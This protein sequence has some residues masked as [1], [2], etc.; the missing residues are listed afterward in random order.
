MN[1][2]AIAKLAVAG[3]LSGSLAANLGCKDKPAQEAGTGMGDPNIDYGDGHACAGNNSC[4]GLGGCQVTAD[5]L[6]KLAAAAGVDAANAGEPHSCAG[7]NACKGLGGCAVTEAKLA[8]LKAAL[9][10]EEP[11][12]EAEPAEEPAG[13][14]AAAEEGE[15]AEAAQ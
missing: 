13:E 15:P 7:K 8:E 4:K 2:N 12:E 6:A 11:A 14:E 5:Q 9:P 3:L 1:G 10:A